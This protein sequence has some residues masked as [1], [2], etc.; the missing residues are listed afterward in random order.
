MQMVLVWR[1]QTPG[2]CACAVLESIPLSPRLRA[3]GVDV[4]GADPWV[5][6]LCGVGGGPAVSSLRGVASRMW[7]R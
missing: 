1:A 5:V 3:N 7:S 2:W 6:C 4:E